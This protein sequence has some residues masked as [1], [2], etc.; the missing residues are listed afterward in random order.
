MYSSP[1]APSSARPP[2]VQE[3]LRRAAQRPL[4]PQ[5][6]E[7]QFETTLIMSGATV[8]AYN[9]SQMNMNKYLISRAALLGVSCEEGGPMAAM[10]LSRV[11]QLTLFGGRRDDAVKCFRFYDAVKWAHLAW[12]VAREVDSPLLWGSI[13]I[14]LAFALT[15][16]LDHVAA[17]SACAFFAD[18]AYSQNTRPEL[19]V[20]YDRILLKLLD[21]FLLAVINSV[22]ANLGL[23]GDPATAFSNGVASFLSDL[24]VR[25]RGPA[26]K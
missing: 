21:I 3:Y 12:A 15:L 9:S 2:R 16:S 10:C 20:P 13:A 7:E 14:P 22:R 4:S 19:L 17:G 25:L 18:H 24:R 8:S 23:R 26:Y 6:L 5:E 11:A 1:R